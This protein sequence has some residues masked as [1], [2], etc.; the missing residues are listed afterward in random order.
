MK[1]ALAVSLLVA[2][3]VSHIWLV[4]QVVRTRGAL[5]GILCCILPVLAPFWGWDQ[6]EKRAALAWCAIF[7]AYALSLPLM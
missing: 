4:V 5:R 3:L 6:G 1:T 2:L 7:T